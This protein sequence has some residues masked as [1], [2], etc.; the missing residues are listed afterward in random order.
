MLTFHNISNNK[1]SSSLPFSLIGKLPNFPSVENVSLRLQIPKR[2][3]CDPQKAMCFCMKQRTSSLDRDKRAWLQEERLTQMSSRQA[4]QSREVNN[5]RLCSFYYLCCQWH[6]CFLITFYVLKEWRTSR[7]PSTLIAAPRT[8]CTNLRLR[9]DHEIN[10]THPETNYNERIVISRD[11]KHWSE[12]STKHLSGVMG[13][14]LQ[15]TWFTPSGLE[16]VSRQTSEEKGLSC[17]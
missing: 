13:R 7:N 8:L 14:H 1:R 15:Q 11:Q 10:S 17:M 16:G 12:K 4:I 5:L 2:Y 9:I 6:K 3:S